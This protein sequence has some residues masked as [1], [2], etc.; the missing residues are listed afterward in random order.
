MSVLMVYMTCGSVDEATSIARALVEK[1]L[2]ACANVMPPH[3]A[4]YEWQGAVRHDDETTVIMKTTEETFEALKAEIL[5]LHS[6][7]VPCITAWP[8]T[9]GHVSFIDWVKS[10][11]A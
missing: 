9:Q 7:D 5:K 6:Y 1:Q 11:T 10:Q 8:V 4:V 3:I 2:A